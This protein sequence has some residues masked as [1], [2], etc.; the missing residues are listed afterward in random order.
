MFSADYWSTRINRGSPLWFRVEISARG[1]QISSV[2]AS[3]FVLLFEGSFD[4][5]GEETASSAYLH[6]CLG[7]SSPSIAFKQCALCRIRYLK[8]HVYYLP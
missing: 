7:A 3:R 6:R 4:L 8:V 5:D 1:A 2:D